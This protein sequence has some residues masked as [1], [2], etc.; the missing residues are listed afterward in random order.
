MIVHSRSLKLL[1]YGIFVYYSLFQRS[2]MGSIGVQIVGKRW[3]DMNLLAIAAA[4]DRVVGSF[5]H[6]NL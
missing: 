4:I 6:P 1:V 5:N 2:Q 3:Q